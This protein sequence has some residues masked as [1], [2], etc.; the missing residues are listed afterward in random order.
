[1]SDLVGLAYINVDSQLEWLKKTA[2][3]TSV[4]VNTSGY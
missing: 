3:L 4:Y 2:M 1:M